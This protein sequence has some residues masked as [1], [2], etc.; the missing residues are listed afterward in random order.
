MNLL[1][2]FICYILC[3][4]KRCVNMAYE[5]RICVNSYETRTDR[6]KIA[7]RRRMELPAKL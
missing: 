4:I 7:S 6:I 1:L 5:H 2:G 3:S